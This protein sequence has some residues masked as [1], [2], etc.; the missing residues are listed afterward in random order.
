[1]L[2]HPLMLH[3]GTSAS[4]G[5]IGELFGEDAARTRTIS[6][7][8]TANTQRQRYGNAAPRQVVQGPQIHALLPASKASALGT[9][10]RP[11]AGHQGYADQ[12]CVAI[13]AND[14]KKT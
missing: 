2:R 8:K 5:Q 4:G 14:A 9:R 3:S 11:T 7:E 6:A 10:C 12:V 13:Y 1:M